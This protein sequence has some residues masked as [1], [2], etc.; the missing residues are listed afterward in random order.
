MALVACKRP[1]KSATG[2]RGQALLELVP[3][4][5][6]MIVIAFGVVETSY[7]IWQYEVIAALTREGS[8]LASRNTTL[9]A[10]A[11]AVIHDGLVL[12]NANSGQMAV[13][14]TA[15]QNQGGT[16]KITGQATAGSLS[17]SSRVGNVVEGSAV[18]PATAATVT[19]PPSGSIPLDAS[20][21]VTEVF[22]SYSGI[23][24]LG[25]FVKVTMPTTLYDVAYF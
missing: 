19:P 7:A 12:K 2:E 21:Y 15:V 5:M 25:A 11:T 4:A 3:V 10:S 20:I 13:I 8:N 9:P 24:P 6:L 14:V 17:A 23:T 1:R 22:T 18:I 16:F